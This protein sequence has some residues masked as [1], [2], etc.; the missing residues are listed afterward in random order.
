[1][2]AWQR[3]VG[4]HPVPALPNNTTGSVTAL[5]LDGDGIEDIA[6]GAGTN[7]AYQNPFRPPRIIGFPN[8]LA[9][10]TQVAYVS[11]TSAEAKEG[12]TYTDTAPLEA[13]TK[14]FAAPIW[15]VKS[16]RAADGTGPNSFATTSYFYDSLRASAFGRGPQG[17][18]SVRVVEPPPSSVE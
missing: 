15:V 3:Y 4:R 11:I 16:V 14:Y 7:W 5:D 2:A 8:G 9:N 18:H 6:L 13:G 17:F 1:P 10:K 12:G